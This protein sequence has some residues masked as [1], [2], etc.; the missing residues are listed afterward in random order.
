MYELQ[1]SYKGKALSDTDA[2]QTTLSVLNM[3]SRYAWDGK[4]VLT[5]AAFALH[6]G[7]FWLLAQIYS[8]N[9]LAEDM[10]PLIRPLTQVVN[11]L[12]TTILEVTRCVAEF[13]ELPSK[14]ITPEV[15]ALSKA[16]ADIP[17]VVYWTIRSIVTCATH[18][19]SFTRMGFEYVFLEIIIYILSN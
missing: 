16:L 2:Q 1:I 14:Y 4:L 5:L 6:Y 17:D 11:D 13:R 3:I 10:T 18:I 7:E 19:T 12:I 8:T 9:Q 15:R